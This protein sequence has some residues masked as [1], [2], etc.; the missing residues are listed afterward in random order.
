MA[1]AQ[2][3]DSTR[4]DIPLSIAEIDDRIAS[5][6]DDLRELSEQAAAYS[7]AADEELASDRIAEREAELERL[8]KQRDE[9]TRRQ[10]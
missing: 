7:G 5:V 1:D 8:T 9:L 3:G 4:P 10:S 2:R 6:T